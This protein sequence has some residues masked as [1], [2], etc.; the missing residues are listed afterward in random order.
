MSE[1]IISGAELLA[2]V[3][4]ALPEE[5][6]RIC[7]RPDLIEA[8]DTAVGELEEL[9]ATPATGRRMA[10]KAPA[11]KA[12]KAK[13][14]Q[15]L[16]AAIEEAS[17]D[18]RFRALPAPEWRTLCDNHAP[19]PGSQLDLMSGYNTDAVLDEAVRASLI[20]PEFDDASWAQLLSVVSGG[21]WNELR[22]C[23]GNV[24]RSVPET[25]KSQLAHSIL[26]RRASGSE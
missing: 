9:E 1:S 19:R 13:Q 16:E 4:P 3:Q 17:A 11:D 5:T 18:F 10:S 7:L 15:E 14:V 20:S 23:A 8:W 6:A 12:E 25:G 26:S 24:N 22:R 2:R 21:E